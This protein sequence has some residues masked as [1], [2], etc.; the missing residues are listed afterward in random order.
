VKA[1]DLA[2]IHWRVNLR[3]MKDLDCD[4]D[5]RSIASQGV[6]PYGVV[7]N[8]NLVSR[9]SL[10]LWQNPL[11]DLPQVDENPLTT[12]TARPRPIRIMG[13]GSAQVQIEPHL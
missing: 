5:I 2:L 7:E 8:F 6:V 4:R 10:I 1:K 3:A 9:R 11:R 12:R 13:M